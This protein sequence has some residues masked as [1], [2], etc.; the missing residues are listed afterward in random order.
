MGK[1]TLNVY[2][3]S[4]GI[5]YNVANNIYLI[6]CWRSLFGKIEFSSD[7]FDKLKV[8]TKMDLLHFLETAQSFKKCYRVSS[9]SVVPKH[10][11]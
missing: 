6:C 3:L 5:L 9:K 7:Q 1:H 2:I 10:F 8:E 11:P 4:S